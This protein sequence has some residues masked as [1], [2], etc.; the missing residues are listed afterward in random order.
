MFGSSENLSNLQ[1]HG[2]NFIYNGLCL[3]IELFSFNPNLVVSISGAL[4][5]FLLIY[6][7]P[8]LLHLTCLYSGQSIKI[9]NINKIPELDD[10]KVDGNANANAEVDEKKQQLSE[11]Q[12]NN[13]SELEC[14]N[15][16]RHLKNNKT[17]TF[18]FYGFIILMG[19][20]VIVF[21]FIGL[22]A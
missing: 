7:I 17:L 3:G 2:F 14:L 16:D 13:S 5:G 4:G 8:I 9:R 18:L 21:E 12:E 11:N 22:F 10:E 19:V 6:I 15:H 1:F 20:G